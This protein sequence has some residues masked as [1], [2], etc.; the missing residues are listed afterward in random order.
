[1]RRPAPTVQL[2]PYVIRQFALITLIGTA[3]VAMFAD[4]ENS[5]LAEAIKARDAKNRLER[6]E[7]AKLGARKVGTAFK[8]EERT[9]SGAGFERL[10]DPDTSTSTSANTPLS[11]S[12]DYRPTFLRDDPDPQVIGPPPNAPKGI[13]VRKRKRIKLTDQ[14][15]DKIKDASHRRSGEPADSASD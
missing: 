11:V 6:Q 8:K 1:M 9:E 7:A 3:L 10:N 14:D 4:G 15:L 13:F 2:S 12:G 5:Q